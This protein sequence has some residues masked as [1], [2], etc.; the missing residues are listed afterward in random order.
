MTNKTKIVSAY[1]ADKTFID[2]GGLWGTKGEMVTHALKSGAKKA[3]MCDA[4]PETS[5]WW[6]KFDSWAS[7]RGVTDYEKRVHDISDPR[8]RE[9]LGTFDFVHCTGVLYHMPDV[10]GAFANLVSIMEE[11]LMVGSQVV[12]NWISNSE[13]EAVIPDDQ[14]LLLPAT[15]DT[16]RRIIKKYYEEIG[17]TN[18]LAGATQ[19]A[20]Y[21]NG[22]RM[23]PS[24]GPW[25]WLMTP[26]FLER[27]ARSL[28]LRVVDRIDTVRTTT[29]L[30]KRR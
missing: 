24:V 8:S 5:E 10:V 23:K 29:L 7:E 26:G 19:P 16:K 3:T 22:E 18:E 1:V 20:K 14:P 30:V 21:F 2:V 28:D 12:P 4:M 13:G 11:H 17:V 27:V 9:K 25:W 15:S 6:Q